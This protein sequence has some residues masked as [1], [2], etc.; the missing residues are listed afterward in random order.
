M[1]PTGGTQTTDRVFVTELPVEPRL[2]ASRMYSADG[3]ARD[4]VRCAGQRLL[5]DHHP[6]REPCPPGVRRARARLPGPLP[7]RPSS[8]GSQ[9]WRSRMSA[10]SLPRVFDGRTGQSSTEKAIVLHGQLPPHKTARI[11]IINL[12]RGGGGDTIRFERTGLRRVGLRRERPGTE[13]RQVP[14]RGRRRHQVAP[15][16]RLSRRADQHQHPV[17][18]SGGVAS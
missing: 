3:A 7:R 1:A 10:A 18:R 4:R 14:E 13:L 12:F 2:F 5:A 6:V 8:A 9:A 17:G 15:R 16:R 11:N